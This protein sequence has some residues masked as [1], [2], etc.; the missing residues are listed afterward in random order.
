MK[1]R[2]SAQVRKMMVKCMRCRLVFPE[3][4]MHKLMRFH[5]ITPGANF[6]E[7]QTQFKYYL[8]H[9]IGKRFMGYMCD[10]CWNGKVRTR[11]IM[12]TL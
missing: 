3:S 7:I 4:K 10:E 1:N 8:V 9:G 12:N 11:I 5:E 6:N 2:P